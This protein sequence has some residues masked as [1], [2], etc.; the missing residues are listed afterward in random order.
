[1]TAGLCY[2]FVARARGG[3]GSASIQVFRLAIAGTFAWLLA[4]ASAAALTASYHAASGT[5]DSH[6]YCATLRTVVLAGMS[7]LLAWA[8]SRWN[9]VELSRLMYPAMVLAAYR[10]LMVDMGQD[11]KP[12]LFL[13]LLVF[14]GA[15]IALPRLA[16][17][18]GAASGTA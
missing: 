7:L 11:Y 15:L 8:G 14:G 5:P 3:G 18:R 6:P 2:L 16:R 13:S 9:R 4:G 1:V 12:A 10:L 17:A